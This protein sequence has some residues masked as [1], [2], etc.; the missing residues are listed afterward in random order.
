VRSGGELGRAALTNSGVGIV[1]AERRLAQG[2]AVETTTPSAWLLV[3][4][5]AVIAVATTMPTRVKVDSVLV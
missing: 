1:V 4:L 2:M 5:S 3:R